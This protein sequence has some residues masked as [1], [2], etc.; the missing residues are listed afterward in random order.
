MM[1]TTST[2]MIVEMLCSTD[3]IGTVAR[4]SIEQNIKDGILEKIEVPITLPVSKLSLSYPLTRRN[5]IL[6]KAID[7][8]IHSVK[9]SS[10]SI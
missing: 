9:R 1:T 4:Q 2:A 7:I 6:R 8:V 5:D 3:A 10:G